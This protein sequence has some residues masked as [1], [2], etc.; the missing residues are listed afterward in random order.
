MHFLSY[1]VY[2]YARII[3]IISD[4]PLIKFH[5]KIISPDQSIANTT[6]RKLDNS[7]SKMIQ[8]TLPFRCHHNFGTKDDVCQLLF[9]KNNGMQKG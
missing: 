5:P 6:G 9:V 4:N 7:I 8:L 3:F 2:M 1:K